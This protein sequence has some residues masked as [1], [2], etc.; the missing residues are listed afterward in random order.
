[1]R[2]ARA[3]RCQKES[4]DCHPTT[5]HRRESAHLR[6]VAL[7]L[8]CCKHRKCTEKQKTKVAFAVLLHFVETQLANIPIGIPAIA[9]VSTGI[10]HVNICRRARYTSQLTVV[11]HPQDAQ[12]F[13]PSRTAASNVRAISVPQMGCLVA[14]AYLTPTKRLPITPTNPCAFSLSRHT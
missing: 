9:S 14:R 11:A 2:D 1:M 8:A 7:G 10:L 6:R 12:S 4:S 3:Y 13:G 5:A